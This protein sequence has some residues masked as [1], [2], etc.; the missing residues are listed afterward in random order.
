MGDVAVVGNQGK[1]YN[2]I[3]RIASDNLHHCPTFL[4]LNRSTYFP[5][6][7]PYFV[8]FTIVQKQLW[9]F[10]LCQPTNRIID[11]HELLIRFIREI[12]ATCS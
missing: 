10:L 4:R 5:L 2:Y 9:I 3:L 6:F 12:N 11:E 1:F 8:S 7:K